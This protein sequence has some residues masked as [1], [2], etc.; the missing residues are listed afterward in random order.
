MHLKVLVQNSD[1]WREGND[2]YSVHYLTLSEALSKI[3]EIDVRTVDSKE[4]IK[5]ENANLARY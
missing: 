5:L 2:V 1:R 4:T 3:L